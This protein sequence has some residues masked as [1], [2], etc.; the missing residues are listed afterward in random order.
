MTTPRAEPSKITF[1][2]VR[3]DS[4]RKVVQEQYIAGGLSVRI[5]VTS[6]NPAAGTISK[7]ELEIVGGTNMAAT[8]FRPA[9]E[10]D[11]TL[12][13][14][15]RGNPVSPFIVPAEFT[16]VV[17]KVQRPGLAVSDGLAIGK[18]LQLGGVLSLGQPAPEGGLEVT[19][20]SDDPE[21]LLI[22]DSLTTVGKKS[23][24][25]KLAAGKFSERYSLQALGGAGTVT[26][27]AIC[28]RV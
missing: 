21:K 23:I 10:G 13:L 11:S 3:L 22:S 8:M 18:N 7:P 9:G 27:T 24:T 25:L 5:D 20:V 12:S 2:A 15:T 14:R 26:Y 6:S 19:L 4:S 16:E 17:A 1:L 28:F